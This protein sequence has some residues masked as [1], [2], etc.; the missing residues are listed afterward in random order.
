MQAS[1]R[2]KAMETSG[3]EARRFWSNSR[4]IISRGKPNKPAPVPL[5]PPRMSPE[6]EPEAPR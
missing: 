5:H 4:I 2:V 1:K 6:T 3:K